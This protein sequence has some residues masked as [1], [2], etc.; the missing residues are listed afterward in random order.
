MVDFHN[1]FRNISLFGSLSLSPSF[2]QIFSLLT[3]GSLCLFG[4]L[5]LCFCLFNILRLDMSLYHYYSPICLSFISLV[6]Y[7][8][9]DNLYKVRYGSL[10]SIDLTILA[11]TSVVH[12]NGL[13]VYGKWVGMHWILKLKTAY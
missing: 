13:M 5:V 6:I 7:L 4:R 3:L 8:I 10:S 1:L 12:R 2:Y 11:R 9:S